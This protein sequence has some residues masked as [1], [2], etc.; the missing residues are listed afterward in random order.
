M[1]SLCLQREERRGAGG[2]GEQAARHAA[3][4]RRQ[5]PR[6]R[7]RPAAAGVGVQPGGARPRPGLTSRRSSSTCQSRSW[8]RSRQVC[9]ARRTRGPAACTP[10]A[11]GSTPTPASRQ[12]ATPA[13]AGGGGRRQ[14]G[15]VRALPSNAAPMQAAA[16]PG[17]RSPAPSCDGNGDRRE[18]ASRHASQQASRRRQQAGASRN[19]G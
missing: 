14:G 3:P 10:G 6:A 16:C 2:R 5:V 19:A 1:S 17:L 12:T 15:C 13:C 18:Q 7:R 11:A 9:W 8:G 4:R